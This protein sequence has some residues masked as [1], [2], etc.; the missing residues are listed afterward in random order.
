MDKRSTFQPYRQGPLIITW[1]DEDPHLEMTITGSKLM[2]IPATTKSQ[3]GSHTMRGRPWRR[4][5]N[6]F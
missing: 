2:L 6:S 1:H 5:W 3:G 4:D